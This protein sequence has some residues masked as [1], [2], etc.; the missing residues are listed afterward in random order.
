[1]R[2]FPAFFDLK[3]RPVFVV[4][5]GELAVRKLRLLLKA[6]PQIKVFSDV[7]WSSEIDDFSG[8]EVIPR[9]LR[10]ED[11]AVRPA[12][13]VA[14]TDDPDI[15]GEAARLAKL[16]GVPVNVVDQPELC[17]VVIPSIV[18]RGDVAIGISTG[19]AA[20]VLGRRL[21]ERIESLLPARLGELVE[22]ARVRRDVVAANV[23]PGE[24]RRFWERLFEGP[25]AEAVYDGDMTGAAQG[26]DHAVAAGGAA[27]GSIH[28]VGAGP[29]DPELLTLKALRVLQEADIVLYDNLVST[30]ILDLIRRDAERRYVGKRKADH[31]MPQEDIGAL[32]IDL[33][34]AGKRVVR[35]K[36][37]DPFI[38]GRGGEELEQV[39]AAGLD[40]V[41]VPGITAAA[42]CAAAAS[43]PLT[44][45]GM[46]Q[47]VSY[48]TASAG[49]GG[50]PDLDWAALARLKHTVVV[51]MGVGRA[52]EVAA[53]LMDGG[54]D[55]RT[56]VAVVEKGTTADQK[57]L[58]TTLRD[59]S[60]DIVRAA[61]VGPA[62]LIIGEVAAKAS[63]HG[64][65]EFLQ[66]AEAA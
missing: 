9:H 55:T 13:L 26:F 43:T 8:V 4:G 34:R 19:G 6:S 17:D 54:L 22:F 59:L 21:R 44:H 62:V 61:I 35:L 11:F 56:P 37:G 7:Q 52:G 50:A 48:V 57:I 33:A 14:A 58:R 16:H 64:L 10:D 25:V 28:I 2:Y 63:G 46:S 42:G 39:R 24:R 45:R 23:A 51:Y 20:P 27:I 36:G 30:D 40:A 18:D 41:V 15:D 29:G 38:F 60:V 66:E 65:T 32:M 47:A 49:G 1:M 31:S 12:L 53:S 3:D 5:G